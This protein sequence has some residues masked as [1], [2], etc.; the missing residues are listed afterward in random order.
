[1]ISR[2]PQQQLTL[3]PKFRLQTRYVLMQS[4]ADPAIAATAGSSVFVIFLT[5]SEDISRVTSVIPTMKKLYVLPLAYSQQ[6][7]LKEMFRCSFLH[8]TSVCLARNAQTNAIPRILAMR[9]AKSNSPQVNFSLP[10]KKIVTKSLHI[11]I[12]AQDAHVTA[13][14]KQIS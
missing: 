13:A 1:M 14:N 8:M 6:F 12:T 5:V 3:L 7:S 4:F 10:Q 9:S 2:I 11:Q